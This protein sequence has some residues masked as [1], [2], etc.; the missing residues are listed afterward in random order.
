MAYTHPGRRKTFIPM[1]V[2]ETL[3]A[4]SHRHME[5]KLHVE[6]HANPGQKPTVNKRAHITSHRKE[7]Y[8]DLYSY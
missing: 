7:G 4:D 3:L 2:H 8:A 1:R 6:V 5:K